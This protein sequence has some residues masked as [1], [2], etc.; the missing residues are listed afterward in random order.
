[1]NFAHTEDRRML[2]DTL[3]RFVSEQYAIEARNRI[4]YGDEGHSPQ[5]YAQLAELGAIGA[6]FPES[7]GGF[8]G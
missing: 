4:A 6:L 1:M 5:L 8:G 7:E 3:G 2:A